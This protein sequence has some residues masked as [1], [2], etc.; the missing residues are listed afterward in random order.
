LTE[1]K[2][3]QSNVGVSNEKADD[4][5]GNPLHGDG[6]SE[7]IPDVL[8]LWSLGGVVV[9]AIFWFL[10]FHIALDILIVSRRSNKVLYIFHK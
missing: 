9:L 2:V 6:F 5:E 8:P 4:K 10:F 1:L 7:E 3:F